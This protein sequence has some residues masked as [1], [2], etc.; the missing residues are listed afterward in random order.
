MRAGNIPY[1][2]KQIL[3]TTTTHEHPPPSPTHSRPQAYLSVDLLVSR[4][5]LDI[6]RALTD[7]AMVLEALSPQ[8]AKARK[9]KALQ[10]KAQAA[11]AAK[12]A[13]QI[14]K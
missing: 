14:G 3:H 2:H 8:G 7:A 13:K 12:Q 10:D 5:S 11:V 4:G 1:T 9:I 6:V